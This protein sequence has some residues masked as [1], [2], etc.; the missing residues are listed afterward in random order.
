MMHLNIIY[1][2][3]QYIYIYIIFIYSFKKLMGSTEQVRGEGAS[4]YPR[5]QPLQGVKL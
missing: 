1:L 2:P 3:L 4:I 5:H